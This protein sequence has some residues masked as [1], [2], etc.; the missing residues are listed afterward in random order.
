[1]IDGFLQSHQ[2]QGRDSIADLFP[3]GKRCGLYILHFSNGEIYAGQTL[4]ITRRYVQHRKIHCDIE[5]I[6]FRRVAKKDLD[7]EE[8][9]LIWMLERGDNRL[10]NI[11]FT[12][13]PKGES[14][15]DLIISAEN[16]EKWLDGKGYVDVSGS[17]VVNPELR[18]KYSRNFQ[19][20][21]ALPYSNEIAA[22]LREYICAGIPSPLRSELSFWAR[23]CLPGHSNPSVTI[24]SRININWQ[25]VLTA[26]SYKGN[27]IFSFHLAL[28]PLEEAFGESLSLLLE[29]FPSLNVTEHFYEPGGQNQINLEIEGTESAKVLIQQKEIILATRLFNL[30]LMKKGPCAYS[31][32]HCMDL[33]DRLIQI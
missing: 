29:K 26:Y 33:A 12:S 23:S 27:I 6:S 5:K 8:R 20:F 11:I 1:M 31:R 25:E 18:R 7:E 19:R 4:D 10:R 16:Q 22:V 14:D 30:R 32:Y 2:V 3:S 17:R 9:A 24:Y 13:I 21:V 15:L 28:S